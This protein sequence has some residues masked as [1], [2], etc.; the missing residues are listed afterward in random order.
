M[1]NIKTF[2][3]YG[4]F[5]L[6]PDKFHDKIPKIAN[7]TNQEINTVKNIKHSYHKNIKLHLVMVLIGWAIA[8]FINKYFPFITPYSQWINSFGVS[9]IA[10]TTLSKLGENIFT[11]G[12]ESL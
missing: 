12:R 10:I 8:F 3:F 6:F 4:L 1:Q 5:F 11:W 2:F 9:L 7:N